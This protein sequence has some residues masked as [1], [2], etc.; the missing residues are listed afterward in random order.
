MDSRNLLYQLN[1]CG[2][3]LIACY[4]GASHADEDLAYLDLNLEQLLDVPVTGSTLTEESLKT[5]PAAVSVFTHAQIERLGVDY[6]YEL[7]NLVPGFQFNRNASN[8]AAYT[9]SARGRRSTQQSLEVL[10]LIDGHVVNDPRAGSPDITLPFYPLARVER[11][12]VIRGPGSAIYGSSAFNGVINIV[13]RK[14][15]KSI[16]LAYGSQQRRALESLWA[17]YAG[18]WA[19]DGF[20]HAYKDEGDGFVVPDSFS[21]AP[22]ATSDPRQQVGLD[23]ALHHD[24]TRIHLNYNRVETKDFYQSDSTANGFNANDRQLLHLA[25]DQGFTWL[26]ATRS[27]ISLSYQQFTYDFDLYV[28][29]PGQLEQYSLPPSAEPFTGNAR[30]AGDSWRFTFTNDWSIDT[31]SSTQWGLQWARHEETDANALGNFDLIQLSRGQYPITFYGDQGR[32]FPIGTEDSQNNLG[33]YLQYLRN[34]RETTRLTLGGR[35]DDY[36]DLSGRFSPRLGLVEQLSPVYSLKLLYGE[37]FRAPT[38]AEIGLINNPV[39]LGNADLRH[40]IV[41]TWDLILMGNWK[42]TSLSLGVFE[43]HYEH[44]IGTIFIGAAARTYRNGPKETSR[45]LEVEWS[46]A[47][48]SQWSLRSTYTYMDLPASAF[49]EAT[50]M[51]SVEVNYATGKWNWNL[52]G[53][54]QD[55]RQTPVTPTSAQTLDDFWMLNTRWRYQISPGYALELSIKNLTDSDYPTPSQSLGK[56]GGIP[57]RGREASVAWHWVW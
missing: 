37:A 3:L 19:I 57:N 5:V 35:Y 21:G 24:Q 18:E 34:L 28:T 55:E 46:Q 45:G 53:V 49:R 9:Y 50:Q 13:T 52:L 22:L 27:K 1:L 8:G 44:P 42:T 17:M 16:A 7:L 20:L 56:P 33:V 14:Q 43:N 38:L 25:L 36:A 39:L 30:L 48:S 11:L 40:E 32:E 12:E 31:Q 23:L 6:L 10:L 47:L 29:G 41:K 54:Y 4:P 51:A 2:W 26:P 15:Q